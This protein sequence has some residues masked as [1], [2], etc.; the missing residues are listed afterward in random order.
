MTRAELLEE[1]LVELY[2]PRPRPWHN[3][4]IRYAD[5][6]EAERAELRARRQQLLQQATDEGA[7]PPPET[8]G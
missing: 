4:V 1:L 2:A 7:K 6:I 3:P 5:D 8:C